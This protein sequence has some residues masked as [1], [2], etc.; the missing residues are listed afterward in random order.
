MATRRASLTVAP[1]EHCSAV[2]AAIERLRRRHF[3]SPGLAAVV[4]R[5]QQRSTD[6]SA[7]SVG[8]GKSSEAAEG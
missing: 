7:A 4:E 6:V 3:A 5:H 2:V 1:P 8:S